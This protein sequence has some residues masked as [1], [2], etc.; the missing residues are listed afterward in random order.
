ML[1]HSRL[2]RNLKCFALEPKLATTTTIK[3]FLK[4]HPVI[5]HVIQ[6]RIRATCVSKSALISLLQSSSSEASD[7]ESDEGGTSGK[8]SKSSTSGRFSVSNSSAGSPS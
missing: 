6:L 1:N 7:E 8:G 2:S 4:Q 5:P 3:D